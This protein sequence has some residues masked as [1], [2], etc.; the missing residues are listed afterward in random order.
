MPTATTKY[1]DVQQTGVAKVVLQLDAA[2]GN[3]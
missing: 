3:V 1:S 2:N